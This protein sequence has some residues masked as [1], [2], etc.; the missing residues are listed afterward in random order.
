MSRRHLTRKQFNFMLIFV[1]SLMIVLLWNMPG[2][3]RPGQPKEPSTSDTLGD[4]KVAPP[5]KALAQ[6]APPKTKPQ[7]LDSLNEIKAASPYNINVETWK[8][9]NGAS[10]LFVH[11]PSLPMIDVR[12][13]FNAGAARDG[14]LYGLAKLTNGVM[15]EGTHTRSVDDIARGFEELGVQFSNAS[16]RDMAQMRIRSL[17]NKEYLEPALTLLG[18]VLNKPNFPIDAIERNRQQM[19]VALTHKQQSPGNLAQEAL[20][21]RLYP[22]HS[23]GTPPGGDEASLKAIKRADLVKFHKQ[24]YVANNLTIAIAGAIDPTQA[25]RIS[26]TMSQALPSGV[27]APPIPLQNPLPVNQ[28]AHLEHETSQTHVF[29]GNT[30]IQRH[31]PNYFALYVGNEVLGAGGFSSRLNKAIR[32]DRGLVYSIG[33]YFSAMAANGP[34]AINF[35]TRADQAKEAIHVAKDVLANFIQ[36]GPSDAELQDAKDHIINSFPLSTASNA[37]IVGYIGAMGFYGLPSNY[38]NTFITNI[39][40]VTKEEIVQAFQQQLDTNRLL[41]VTAGPAAPNTT[42]TTEHHANE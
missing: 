39:Q 38:L 14:E 11:L 12:M 18:D 20:M 8:T 24:Y 34:F 23:Y 16:Y 40:A 35:Q 26:E 27:A 30:G 37:Q 3:I 19:Q 13:L 15:A 17:A 9:A 10:V 31:H 32:Q 1:V 29:I 42:I 7:P 4:T 21:A 36:E 22:K 25:K 33:S 41:V 28:S 2:S 6:S 5:E